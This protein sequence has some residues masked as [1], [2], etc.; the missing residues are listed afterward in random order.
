MFTLDRLISASRKKIEISVVKATL[1]PSDVT[2][3]EF[4]KPPNFDYKSGQWMRIACL[5]LNN[6]EYHP[7]TIASAPHEKTLSMFIRA[8]GPFTKNLRQIY[9]SNSLNGRPYPKLYLDG[10]Y[11]EGH[12]DWLKF[13][14]SILVGGGIGITPFASII[15]DITFRSNTNAKINC[16]KVFTQIPSPLLL[17]IEIIFFQVYFLWVTRT[18]KHFEWMSDVIR[19]AETKDRN[20]LLVSHIFITQFYEKF[21]LRTTMLVMFIIFLICFQ[22]EVMHFFLLF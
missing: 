2:H 1:H 4:K 18:Q 20:N 22:G 17:N 19:E 13:D 9:D 10:P 6:N 15:K 16:K 8:V 11:G 3:L 12:Q 14:V 21:D 5:E 7:F